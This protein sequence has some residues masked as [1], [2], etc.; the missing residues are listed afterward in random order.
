MKKMTLACVAASAIFCGSVNALRLVGDNVLTQND[1]PVES[2]FLFTESIASS[3][4][5]SDGVVKFI[6]PMKKIDAYE[7]VK[8]LVGQNRLVKKVNENKATATVELKGRQ[9]VTVTCQRLAQ[10]SK[11]PEELGAVA[12]E[13]KNT[14]SAAGA[15]LA[16]Q[17][18]SPVEKRSAGRHLRLR[19]NNSF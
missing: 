17:A 15:A 8:M 3:D 6:L 5:I 7:A 4:N 9:R 2:M 18:N 14:K 19:T 16:D 10:D 1:L 11:A 12:C 13:V